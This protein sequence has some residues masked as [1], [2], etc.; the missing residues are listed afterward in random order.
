MK[1]RPKGRPISELGWT[2]EQTREA[3]RQMAR[4]DE[5]WDDPSMDAYDEQP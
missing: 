1:E 4:W 5:L 2:P 3:R